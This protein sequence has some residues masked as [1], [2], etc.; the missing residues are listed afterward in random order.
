MVML[1]M[2][3]NLLIVKVLHRQFSA[4]MKMLRQA[5][6][7]IPDSR[8]HHGIQQWYYSHTAYHILETMEFYLSSDPNEMVWG[9]RAGFDEDSVSDIRS[10]ILPLISKE[11]I[12]LYYNEIQDLLD[13]IY[14]T[15]TQEKF[16]QKDGFDWFANIFEKHVYLLRHTQHHLGELALIVREYGSSPV[17]WT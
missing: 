17:K 16:S 12:V 9:K 2:S 6:D 15:L 7:N 3:S 10:E 11:L 4:T 5:I 8:W 13:A 1:A 14:N